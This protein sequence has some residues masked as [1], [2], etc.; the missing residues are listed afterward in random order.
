MFITLALIEYWQVPILD[1]TYIRIL[2]YSKIFLLNFY[3]FFLLQKS[4]TYYHFQ[5]KPTYLHISYVFI[6]KKH[7]IIY[8][9][10]YFYYYYFLKLIINL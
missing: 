4:S 5:F 3:L 1:E 6:F 2:Y 8:L 10:K 7:K 9:V